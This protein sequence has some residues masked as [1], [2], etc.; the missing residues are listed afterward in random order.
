M[1]IRIENDKGIVENIIFV[2]EGIEICKEYIEQ[3]PVNKKRNII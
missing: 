1:M 2:R 3:L